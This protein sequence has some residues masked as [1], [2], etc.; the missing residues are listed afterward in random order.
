MTE[1]FNVEFPN[2]LNEKFL[3]IKSEIE[4]FGEQWQIFEEFSEEDTAIGKEE[5]SIYRRRPYILMD[6]LMKWEKLIASDSKVSIAKTRISNI[7]GKYKMILPILNLLQS[8]CLIEKHWTKIFILL[9]RPVKPYQDILLNDILSYVDDLLEQGDEIKQIIRQATSE[10]IILKVINELE[11]W[12]LTSMLK[13]VSHTDSRGQQITLL[14]DFSDVLNKIGDNQ[15]LLQSAKNSAAYESFSDQ[16]SIWEIK[17]NT[18]DFILTNLNVVQ[19]KWIYLEPIFSAGTLKSEEMVFKR[20]DKDF[21]YIQNEINQDLRVI[22]LY[23]INNISSIIETLQ[24][25][26][27][28]CQATLS[29]YIMAKRNAF[30]RFYFLSDDDLLEILGQSSNEEII[31]KHIT[32]IFPGIAKLRM[33]TTDSSPTIIGICSAEGDTIGL[34]NP[35]PVTAIVEDWLNKLVI[36]MKSVLNRLIMEC[37]QNERLTIELIERYPMQIFTL[38]NSIHFTKLTEKA[39]LSMR[40]NDHLKMIQ[41]EINKYTVLLKE[42]TDILLRFKLRSL[43]MDLVQQSSTVEYLINH[44]VTNEQDWYWLQQMKFYI[45]KDKVNIKM[46]YAEFEYSYEFLGNYNKLVYTKLV[47][48]CYLTLTQAMKLGLGGNPFGPAGTGKTECVK[49]LGAILGR[50]VFVFNCSEVSTTSRV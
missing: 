45:D 31:Q 34:R 49:A 12:A 20:I 47:H 39:I 19:R 35:I 17:L 30:S 18:I 25:Q 42:T 27:A 36:E 48:N 2:D 40:L 23:K 46:V 28:R 8:D 43:L 6:F 3:T 32:K 33:N 1:K 4:R 7:L 13:V 22:S 50:L 9:G 14:K 29:T 44:N 16:A 24:Q 5:W 15:C 37:Y 38:T 26:L 21:R 41:S 10:Q 11:Q